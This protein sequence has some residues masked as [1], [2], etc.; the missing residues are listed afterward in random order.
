MKTKQ[1]NRYLPRLTPIEFNILIA[2]LRSDQ[3][4]LGLIQDIAARTDQEIFLSPGTL[5][6]A[7]K[8]M[9]KDGWIEQ[10]EEAPPA[11]DGNS[12]RRRYYRLSQPGYE[13]LTEEVARMERIARE[14]RALLE[15][16]CDPGHPGASTPPNIETPQTHRQRAKGLPHNRTIDENDALQP[17]STLVL[18]SD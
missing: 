14:T 1:T 12:E 17:R 15:Q 2:L 16:H 9:Y 3:H 4:G 11:N 7:L 18:T 8:R 5:Y 13:I 6:S 10:S